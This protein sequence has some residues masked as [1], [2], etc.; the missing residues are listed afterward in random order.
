MHQPGPQPH[1]RRR[2]VVIGLAG[3]IG[4]GKSSVAGAMGRLGAVV[5]DADAQVR[6]LLATP[7]VRDGL[8]GWWGNG[9]LTAAGEIDRS[10]VGAVVFADPAQRRRLESLLHP[11]VIAE[12]TRAIERA[13]REG[14][15]AVVIDAALLFEAG[16]DALCDAVV[17]VECPR[18]E[19]LERVARTRAWDAAELDRR[20]QT[21]WPLDEKR[22]R[23]RYLVMNDAGNAELEESVREVFRTILRDHAP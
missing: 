22:R 7:A 18:A 6:A 2:P 20:E 4:A 23:C 17:W 5:Q 12:Q 16:A 1:A 21:Q 14:R 13:G 10:R 19:R 11:L 15:P 9:V 8:V 3:G